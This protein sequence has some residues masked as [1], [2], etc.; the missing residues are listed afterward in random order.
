MAKRW[1]SAGVATSGWSALAD[2]SV[3]SD[4]AL[5]NGNRLPLV[6]DAARACDQSS[7]TPT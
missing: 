2:V 1:I 5:N 4:P 6:A 3:G 7:A